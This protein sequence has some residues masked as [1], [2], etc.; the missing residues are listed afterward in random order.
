MLLEAG[1]EKG[2]RCEKDNEASSGAPLRLMAPL[3][4]V[5]GLRDGDADGPP[6][7]AAVWNGLARCR[8]CD[9]D[10]AG[11]AD[12]S[13]LSKGSLLEVEAAK[14]SNGI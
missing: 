5:V 3:G 9:L 1:R 10:R 7:A 4:E 11:G 12:S 13:P 14:L 6:A 8:L 2:N